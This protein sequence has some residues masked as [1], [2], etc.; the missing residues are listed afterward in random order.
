M[1]KKKTKNKHVK[2]MTLPPRYENGFI[3]DLDKRTHVFVS[4]NTAFVEVIADMGG[5][6][7]LSHVQVCLAER[8]VFLKFVLRGIEA[9]IVKNRKKSA[10]LLG[11]WIQGL[12]SLNGL[13]KTVGLERRARQVVNLK[14]YVR[15]KA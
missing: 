7:G 4:L 8:F 3:E 2:L 1:S 5:K 11:K 10:E 6:E 14:E 15:G 13:A 9:D 12:N